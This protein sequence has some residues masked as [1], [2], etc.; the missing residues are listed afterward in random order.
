[1]TASH[2]PR[3][4]AIVKHAIWIAIA[5][6]LFLGALW[7]LHRELSGVRF[8]EV[9]ARFRE[10]PWYAVLLAV[11]F[12]AASYAALAGY[13]WLALRHIGRRLPFVDVA[14]TSFTA[15]AVGHNLGV[16]M[17][18][19][20]AVRYRLYSAAGLSAAEIAT[21]IG[22]IGLTF[23]L[24]V[25]FVGALTLLLATPETTQVLHVSE[26]L[27][28]MLGGLLIAL[29]LGYSIWGGRRREPLRVGG[30]QFQ[31][32]RPSTTGLQVL[33]ALLDVVFAAVVLYVLLPA[34]VGVSY[35]HLLGVYVLAVVAGILSHVPGGLGVFESVLILS[36][37]DAPRDSL[38]GAVLA[39]RAVYYLLPLA[40]AVVL[41]LGQELYRRRT[42]VQRRMQLALDLL[43]RASPQVLAVLV[44]VCG[45]IL[46]FSGATPALPERVMAL[47][48]LLPLPVVEIA[49]ILGS[50]VGLALMMLANGLSRRVNAAYYLT[51]WLLPVAIIASLAKGLDYE[52]ATLAALAIM[53]L[54]AGRKRFQRHTSLLATRL[55]PA[56]IS[57]LAMALFGSLWLGMFA[58][59]HVDYSDELWWRFTLQGDAPRFLRASLLLAL[60]VIGFALVKLMRPRSP[61]PSLPDQ[62]TLNR[63]AKIVAGSSN[64]DATLALLGDKRILLNAA[65]DGFVMYQVRRNSW[66]AL[67]DP[68]GPEP[69]REQLAWQFREL[70]E[71][72]NG[73]TIFYQ[74]DAENL[75]LYVD[76]GLVLLK[77]GEEALVP[78]DGFSPRDGAT[79]ELRHAYQRAQREKVRFEVIEPH[80]VAALITPLQA[81]SEQWLQARNMRQKGFAL[82]RFEP[83][84]IGRCRC[85]L[86]WV[87]DR[88]VA[89]ANLLSGAGQGEFSVDF[90]RYSND[91]PAGSMDYLF[92]ELL[93]WGAARGYRRFNLGMTPLSG[94]ESHPLAPLWQRIGALLFRHGEHFR[95]LEDLRAYKE[96]FYPEWR[97]KYLAAPRGLGLPNVLLDVATLISGGLAKG[98]PR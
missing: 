67:G 70:C 82:G 54:Y 33:F 24:G 83:E 60:A 46:V 23:G 89:F 92:T 84:Y 11:G 34:D 14:L 58:Y 68:V 59:R 4:L 39:Y 95:N 73:R 98:L 21:V 38:L 10:L 47:G 75:S 5:L 12:T 81:L 57:L 18:S 51:F 78:L 2:S 1:M 53:A 32:P 49:H 30:W 22:L 52:E 37:P 25:S 87:G 41:G 85:A 62:P 6:L 88:I 72:Y 28:R 94:L 79:A 16:A 42:P 61:E 45:A 93:L 8:N 36:L 15:T 74:V 77:L 55:S 86:L 66:I 7:V 19:G 44:F 29:L 80:R 76:M 64:G 43:G 27:S 17:L 9:L 3:L 35:P 40:V 71:Q 65:G 31:V 97:P 56:W 63:L 13:D 48:G 50:L 20:G 69:V 96:K 26:S 91:A 90:M